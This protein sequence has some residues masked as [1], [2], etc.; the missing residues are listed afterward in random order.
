MKIFNRSNDN[1][2]KIINGGK[3]KEMKNNENGEK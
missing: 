1:V 2:R 3:K